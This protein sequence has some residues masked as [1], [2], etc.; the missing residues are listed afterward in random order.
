MPNF[1]DGRRR[2][3]HRVQG[4]KMTDY[5]DLSGTVRVDGKDAEDFGSDEWTHTV[6]ELDR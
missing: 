3:D 4:E 2:G 1:I 6:H 5:R